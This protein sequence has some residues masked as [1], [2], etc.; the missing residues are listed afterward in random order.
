M[1][2]FNLALLSWFEISFSF[3]SYSSNYNIVESLL[4]LFCRFGGFNNK[5]RFVK[6]FLKAV[7]LWPFYRFYTLTTGITYIGTYFW[8]LSNC[9]TTFSTMSMLKNMIVFN[10]MV[11]IVKKKFW[12][13]SSYKNNIF[14]IFDNSCCQN[15]SH[16]C[17][18]VN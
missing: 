5:N 17:T 14:F 16:N 13:L 6:I 18:I 1:N 9:K 3:Y 10:L 4:N 11:A 8:E 15:I 2:Y 12:Q 7:K